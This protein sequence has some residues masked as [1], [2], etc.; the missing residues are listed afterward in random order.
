MMS[1]TAE[2]NEQKPKMAEVV[3]IA[4]ALFVQECAR[5]G[6]PSSEEEAFRLTDKCFIAAQT[7]I[8]YLEDKFRPFA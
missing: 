4:S 8:D 6:A 3:N 2:R 1:S 5:L 7:M